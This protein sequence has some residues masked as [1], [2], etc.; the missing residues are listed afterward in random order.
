MVA[1]AETVYDAVYFDSRKLLSGQPHTVA[2]PAGGRVFFSYE[3]P[4]AA[5]TGVCLIV[6][7]EAPLTQSCTIA[8]EKK[9]TSCINSLHACFAAAVQNATAVSKAAGLPPTRYVLPMQWSSNE[10][11]RYATPPGGCQCFAD[12]QK[13]LAE[14]VCSADIQTAATEL[15]QFCRL[16]VA[17]DATASTYGA[18]SCAALQPV[19]HSEQP[20][21]NVFV[22]KVDTRNALANPF[23]PPVS[24]AL[25]RWSTSAFA[26]KVGQQ[27]MV[28]YENDGYDRSADTVLVG[29]ASPNAAAQVTVTATG[30]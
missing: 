15:Q 10:R 25:A 17:C 26:S 7:P 1:C 29:V 16:S 4:T 21:L 6:T 9:A 2:L 30:L 12:A 23:E 11:T 18:S 22:Q 3:R 13:C 27:R 8:S 14:D 20:S 19:A 28:I 24:A 5:A